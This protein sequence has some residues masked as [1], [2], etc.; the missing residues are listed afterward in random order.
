MIS[1]DYKEK[2]DIPYRLV[3]ALQTDGKIS[4][5]SIQF[6]SIP[7]PVG[8]INFVSDILKLYDIV[9]KYVE[10]F[11]NNEKST[12]LRRKGNEKF[13]LKKDEE[14]LETYTYSVVT[15]E[16][17]SETLGL[18][19]A[20][21][22]AVLFKLKLYNECLQDIERALQ[23]NYPETLKFKLLERQKKA[24]ILT[25]NE[26]KVAYHQSAPSI[27]EENQNPLIECSSSA[28]EIRTNP[29]LG[30]YV[31][32]T[33]DIEIGEVIAVEQPTF[34]LLTDR[35]WCHCHH[36]LTLC[37]C[38]VPCE[39]C[40]QALFCST[41][42]KDNAK[43]YH[44]YECSILSTIYSLD[45]NSCRILPLRIA[46]L[47]KDTKYKNL[48]GIMH[49][50]DQV[51]KSG[52]YEEIHKLVTNL[53]MRSVADLFERVTVSAIFYQ[54][55]KNYTNF[56]KDTDQ[57]CEDVF[58]T[59]VLHHLQT[60]A[61]NFHDIENLEM[62]EVSGA[63]EPTT[64]GAGAYNFLS[65]FN[66]SCAPTVYR[67]SFGTTIVLS[68]VETI[69]KGDQLF[70]NYGFHY[71]MHSKAD[72][73]AALKKQYFFECNCRACKNDWGT[74]DVLPHIYSSMNVLILHY[75]KLAEAD[76]KTAAKI[77]P[78][79]ITALKQME[80]NIPCKNFCEIQELLKQCYSIF[81]NIRRKLQEKLTN[82]PLLNDDYASL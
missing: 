66:H 29:Q 73:Q 47:M 35:Q 33:R 18:A 82:Y 39:F 1:E 48:E 14:A 55:V 45:M 67:R 61:C 26:D 53:E 43:K 68:S 3:H 8:K 6:A 58:K 34:T 76:L 80:K 37:Y 57:E 46:I 7:T 12:E 28:V 25:L 50:S 11:K 77:E 10:N 36:C 9:P 30:R 60:M 13:G 54:L 70:E 27:V 71:A 44:D 20:N 40:T 31:V 64:I 21:R 22:S 15:A 59:L 17:D 56:F 52:R 41:E 4:E 5:T 2:I 78:E 69:K 38:L 63:Y 72:R 24:Q 62:N 23:N 79:V 42:C 49:R 19:Y 16:N 75:K 32:A 51:Y 65:L 74:F 81:S